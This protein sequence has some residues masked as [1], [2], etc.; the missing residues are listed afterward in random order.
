MSFELPAL[1][2][3][4]LRNSGVAGTYNRRPRSLKFS[5]LRCWVMETIK[6]ADLIA[7]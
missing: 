4:A 7:K 5:E 6:A 3:A 1:L 2:D